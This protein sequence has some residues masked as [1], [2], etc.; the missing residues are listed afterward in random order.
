MKT[1]W[2]AAVA[3]VLFTPSAFAGGH[4]GP[5]DAAAGEAIFNRCQSCHVVRNDAGDV[6]AGRNGRTGPNLFGM[7]GR[8]AGSVEDF[9]YRPDLAAAGAD[10]LVWDAESMAAWI[11][12][13]SAFLREATGNSSARAGM[14]PQRL[15]P[16]EAQN[17]VAFIASLDG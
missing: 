8:Q 15:S 17:V 4:G 9:R 16:E 11:Q 12:D 14:P 1:Y 13:P 10:G 5:G 7:V 2:F 3:S 6:L